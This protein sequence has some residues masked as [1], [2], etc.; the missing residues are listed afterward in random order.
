MDIGLMII[1]L[2]GVSVLGF[3]L[4]FSVISGNSISTAIRKGETLLPTELSDLYSKVARDIVACL[5]I[6]KW[7]LFS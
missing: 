3:I 5:F 7:N 1:L 6:S 2:S 4:L